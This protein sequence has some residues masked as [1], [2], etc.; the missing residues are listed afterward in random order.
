MGRDLYDASPAARAV[1]ERAEDACKIPL[2]TLCFEGPADQLSRTD[3]AQ[4]AIFTVSAAVLAAMDERLDPPRLEALRPDVM[5]GL[6]LGEYTALYAADA[7]DL[8]EMVRLVARRGQLMQEAAAAV[9][10]G[11]VSV[12][13]LSEEKAEE[14][15]RAAAEGELLVCANFNCP[16]QVVLSGQIGA[17]ERAEAMA[18]A[19]G[20]AGAVRLKVAGAFHCE[21]MRPAAEALAA[22]MAEV[23]FRRPTTPI[24]A[25]VDAA[26]Y[27][28]AEAIRERLLRQLTSPVR[29]QQSM[30][31]L[32]AGGVEKLYEVGPG[33]VLAGLMR[34]IDR[35]VTV[36]SVNTREAVEALAQA[37]AEARGGD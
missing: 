17:C 10:G 33:R 1:F 4:P 23:T 26:A 12:L 13:G 9:P 35:K 24:I 22:A 32:L 25:N 36:T 5:A 3:V 28:S 20:A 29:W 7:L 15:C 16:G 37:P 18:K 14:L 34:R 2:R 8:E 19:F 27:R 6:S 30:E 21:L 31:N 11:M